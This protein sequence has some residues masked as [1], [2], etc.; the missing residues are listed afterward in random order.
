MKT[1]VRYVSLHELE[2]RLRGYEKRY[3]VSSEDLP[4]AF[5]NGVLHETDDMREWSLLYRTWR[6][7]SGRAV[8]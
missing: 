5:R 1:D 8:L 3:D 2:D 6:A 4:S 7:L